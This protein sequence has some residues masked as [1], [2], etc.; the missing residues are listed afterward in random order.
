[1][2]SPHCRRAGCSCSTMLGAKDMVGWWVGPYCAP[3]VI[4]ISLGEYIVLQFAVCRPLFVSDVAT[5]DELGFC[6]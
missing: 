1:M 2:Q 3:S 6:L 4:F 5:V